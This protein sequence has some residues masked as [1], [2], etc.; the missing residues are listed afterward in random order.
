M[1]CTA[2]IRGEIHVTYSVGIFSYSQLLILPLRLFLIFYL[3]DEANRRSVSGVVE[4]ERGMD[5]CLTGE[6]GG[7]ELTVRC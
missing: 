1:G 7:G 6:M 5:E 4:P 3:L 2:P